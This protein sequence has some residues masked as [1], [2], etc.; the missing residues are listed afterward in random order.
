MF[1]RCRH[2]GNKV[3][4]E[5]MIIHTSRIRLSISGVKIRNKVRNSFF[6]YIE[7]PL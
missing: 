4:Q 1:E 7:Y 3:S 6:P 2:E 5:E